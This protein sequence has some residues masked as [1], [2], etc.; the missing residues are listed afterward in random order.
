MATSIELRG[1]K[2]TG[3]VAKKTGIKIGGENFIIAQVED[4]PGVYTT[5]FGT[6]DISFGAV[7]NGGGDQSPAIILGCEEIKLLQ[8]RQKRDRRIIN[9][10]SDEVSSGVR[11]GCQQLSDGVD[12]FICTGYFKT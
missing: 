10:F 9:I 8:S 6:I 1:E 5:E 2:I 4:K 3:W 7:T 12:L 11:I